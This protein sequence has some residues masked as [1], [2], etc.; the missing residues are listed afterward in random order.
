MENGD[1]KCIV[2]YNVKFE[3]NSQF[4]THRNWWKCY[5]KINLENSL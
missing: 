3:Q 2:N 5:I 1:N 4:E